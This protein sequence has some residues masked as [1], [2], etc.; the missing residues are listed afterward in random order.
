MPAGILN[1]NIDQGSNFDKTMTIFESSTQV[2][3]LSGFTIRAEMR[4][5]FASTTFVA[6]TIMVPNPAN[7]KII[8][9]LTAAQTAA[10]TPGIYVYDMET[11]DSAGS[12]ERA[13]Q[14]RVVV[15]PQVTRDSTGITVP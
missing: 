11:V 1:L 3:N 13:L 12:V 9:R 14:G 10:L 6:F 5:A 2:M 8:F 15:S 7:G 4:K